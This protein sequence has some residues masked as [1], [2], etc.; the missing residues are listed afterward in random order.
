MVMLESR[1]VTLGP[2]SFFSFFAGAFHANSMIYNM[3]IG[4]HSRAVLVKGFLPTISQ[5]STNVFI[6]KDTDPSE[7]KTLSQLRHR[8]S[9]EHPAQERERQVH[10]D[11]QDNRKSSAL[12][13]SSWRVPNPFDT[14]TNFHTTITNL[15]RSKQDHLPEMVPRSDY[16]RL[17]RKNDELLDSIDDLNE[18]YHDSGREIFR[19]RERLRGTR[20]DFNREKREM[21]KDLERESERLRIQKT[22]N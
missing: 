2:F 11:L 16:I 14:I 6:N 21:M 18:K 13:G 5:D 20:D 4:S 1:Y 17:A 7:D 22:I 19:L 12:T 9:R 10:P 8:E 15:G 3:L